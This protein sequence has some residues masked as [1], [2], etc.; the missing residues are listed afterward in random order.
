MSINQCLEKIKNEKPQKKI[1]EKTL[2]ERTRLL[3]EVITS[4]H[5]EPTEQY[6]IMKGA[7]LCGVIRK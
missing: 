5:P 1:S 3:L 2:K 7:L 6:R 4:P